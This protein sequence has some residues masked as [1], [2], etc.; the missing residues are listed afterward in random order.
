PPAELEDATVV[1]LRE[2]EQLMC[3]SEVTRMVMNAFGIPLDV[4][5]TQRTFTKE[6]RRAVLARDRH[7]QW[8]DCK[9]RA[10]WSEIHHITWFSR[11][12]KTA[13]HEA[14]AGCSYHH[15]L[16]HKLDIKITVL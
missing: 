5:R 15:H 12:G 16:I 10:S 8:P 11:G 2:L 4:G 7:C 14:M 1:P 13:L 9:L 3:D 6:L